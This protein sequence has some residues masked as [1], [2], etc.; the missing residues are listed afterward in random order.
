MKRFFR[1]LLAV[2]V[3]GCILMPL[4]CHALH[5]D[6]SQLNLEFQNAPE[7]TAYI[8]VLA[9]L[10]SD[11][12]SYTDF[13]VAPVRLVDKC[14]VDGTTQYVYETLAIDENSEIAKYCENGYV[15]L[16]IHSEEVEKLVL[17]KSY[18]YD[19]DVLHFN[20]HAEELYEKYGAFKIAYVGE[21][22]E[23][24]QITEKTRRA[25]SPSEPYAFVANGDDAVYRFFGISPWVIVVIV[26]VPVAVIALLVTLFCLLICKKLGMRKHD[27]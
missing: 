3:C 21:N 18:G 26:V 12:A 8:D 5:F 19:S 9:K 11:D 23:V 20:C 15:S 2:M 1:I 4:S 16:S 14:I 25:Y 13:N 10:D 24:L 17:M 7:G 6:P 27:A 22:G